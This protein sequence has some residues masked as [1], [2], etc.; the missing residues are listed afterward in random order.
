MDYSG[1]RTMDAIIK[2]EDLR[3]VAW[4]DIL[5]FLAVFG[6]VLE[7][8]EELTFKKR[9]NPEGKDYIPVDKALAAWT[10]FIGKDEF[11]LM[12]QSEAKIL[13]PKK[14][15][16][17]HHA[18]DF[19]WMLK[20]LGEPIPEDDI[21]DFIREALGRADD[22]FNINVFLQYMCQYEPPPKQTK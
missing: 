13:D 19:R 10:E 14:Q 22:T 8:D 16:T 6:K 18:E 1:E 21:N 7:G 15:S 11:I 20:Q 2:S 3:D 5:N 17:Q 12:L 4:E 9:F